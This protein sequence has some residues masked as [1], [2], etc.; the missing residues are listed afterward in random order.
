[1]QVERLRRQVTSSYEFLESATDRTT[2]GGHCQD[3]RG[4]SAAARPRPIADQMA[5]DLRA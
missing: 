4:L 1:M 2:Q 3:D 5:A